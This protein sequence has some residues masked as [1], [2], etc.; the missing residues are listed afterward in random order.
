M[1]DT[2]KEKLKDPKESKNYKNFPVGVVCYENF[3]SHDELSD[4]E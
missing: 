4:L 2:T 3:F 1:P